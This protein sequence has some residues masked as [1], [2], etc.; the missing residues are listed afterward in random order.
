MH[1]KKYTLSAQTENDRQKEMQLLVVTGKQAIKKKYEQ[2]RKDLTVQ[3]RMWVIVDSAHVCV[4]VCLLLLL[5]LLL[6]RAWII[7]PVRSLFLCLLRCSVHA[8]AS[9]EQMK[10]KMHGREKLLKVIRQCTASIPCVTNLS[11][12]LDI[13]LLSSQSLA[14]V[15]HT[16]YFSFTVM[17]LPPNNCDRLLSTSR[18]YWKTWRISSRP[19]RR[20]MDTVTWS[21]SWSSKYV[22]NVP[23]FVLCYLCIV[24][25]VVIKP[26]F[27]RW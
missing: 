5:L 24:D 4:F 19:Y 2:L 12:T 21:S 20:T 15:K 11:C 14:R 27:C 6:S 10:S 25:S 9:A 13:Y 3:K 8:Q 7:Y 26:M 22:Y 17:T 16:C 1:T 18:A 23:V